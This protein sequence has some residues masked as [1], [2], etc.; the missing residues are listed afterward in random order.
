MDSVTLKVGQEITLSV[1]RLAYGGDGVAHPNN[2]VFFVPR[3]APGDQVKAKVT[4][5]RRRYGRAFPLDYSSLSP[6]RI[7]AKCSHFSTCG[8]CHYQHLTQEYVREQKLNHIADAFERIGPGPVSIRPIATFKDQWNYR[9]RLTY[10]RARSGNQGYISWIDYKVIEI[11]DCE[12]ASRSLNIFW[13]KLKPILSGFE[14][15]QIPFVFLRHTTTNEL[16]VVLS[17]IESKATQ[18]FLENIHNKCKPL[19]QNTYLYVT[20]IKKESKAALGNTIIPLFG[21]SYLSEKI[22]NIQYSVQPHIFFQTN[23][24]VTERLV[25]DV[26]SWSV[27]Q[28]PKRMLDLYCGGGLFSIALAKKNIPTLGVDVQQAAIHSAERTAL[29]NHVNDFV[30][31]R[32]GKIENIIEELISRKETFDVAVIDP[33][34]KGIPIKIIDLLRQLGIKK[35]LYVSCSPP[36]MARDA[37]VLETQGYKA[38]WVQPYD[39]F[40]HSYHIELMTLFELS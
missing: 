36:T 26:V 7:E 18:V 2:F 4:Q 22:G 33:P 24:K 31:F 38:C 11:E 39:M 20:H 6:H 16:A 28:K 12:V 32:E 29:K 1:D 23:P 15:D 25:Q 34:R 30:S 10:H 13:K 14:P 3:S 8:G 37:K 9:N 5:V 35:L 27:K 17:V 21:P 40:P 19:L